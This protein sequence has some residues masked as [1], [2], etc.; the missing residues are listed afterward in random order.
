LRRLEA[1]GGDWKRPPDVA[2]VTAIDVFRREV[3]ALL[4]GFENH[5]PWFIKE[6]RLCL[7]AR[8]L[9]SL[10]TRPVFVHVVRDPHAVADSLAVRDGLD[11]AAALALWERYNRDAFVASHGWPRLLI[12]YAQLLADP[13]GVANRLY[14]DLRALGVASLIELDEAAVRAWI[15]PGPPHT[16]APRGELD[17]GQQ[18][19]WQSIQDRSILDDGASANTAR[20]RVD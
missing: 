12:D 2:P 15:E 7:L 10:L 1:A 20:R 5:R 8:E 17:A 11:H 6:P 9:L 14:A 3:A 13:F 16:H 18:R 4:D 19:L